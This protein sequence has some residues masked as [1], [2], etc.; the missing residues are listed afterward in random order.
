MAGLARDEARYLS[1][2]GNEAT[3]RFTNVLAEVQPAVEDPLNHPRQRSEIDFGHATPSRLEDLLLVLGG[4]GTA[5]AATP[6]SP[7]SA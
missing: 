2:E 1:L 3:L 5:F 4:R 7:V 6:Q